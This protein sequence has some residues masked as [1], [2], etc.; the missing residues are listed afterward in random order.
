MVA[1]LSLEE[2]IPPGNQNMQDGVGDSHSSSLS[3]IKIPHRFACDLYCV[4]RE[5]EGHQMG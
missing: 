3:R 2:L 5:D 1:F 4:V